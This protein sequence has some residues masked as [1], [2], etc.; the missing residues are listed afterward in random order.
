MQLP[1]FFVTLIV[2]NEQQVKTFFKLT[3]RIIVKCFMICACAYPW[4]KFAN[5]ISENFF[6]KH[7]VFV[8]NM[9]KSFFKG[10]IQLYYKCFEHFFIQV[11]RQPYL[12]KKRPFLFYP[13][14]HLSI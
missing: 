4:L 11:S 9:N 14:R 10:N 12:P 6:I 3:D 8:L 2:I 1:P 13:Y 5:A 7:A